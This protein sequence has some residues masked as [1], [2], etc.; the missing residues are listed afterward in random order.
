M[1]E[2]LDNLPLAKS[3]GPGPFVDAKFKTV[4]LELNS[5]KE[6]LQVVKTDRVRFLAERSQAMKEKEEKQNEHDRVKEKYGR[7]REALEVEKGKVQE[8]QNRAIRAENLAAKGAFNP[9]ETRIL[10][11]S[12]NPLSETLQ[13]QNINLKR[14]LKEALQTKGG[15]FKATPTPQVDVNP[16]KL[17]KRLKQSF[18]EQIGLFREGVHLITG[19]R[20]D[21][22]PNM[23]RH[24]FRVRSM[25]AE[26]EEDQLVFQWPDN[27][28]EGEMP[29]T[30][31][32]MKTELALALQESDSYQYM[33]KFNSLPAFL[34]DVQLRQFEKQTV[35]T[36]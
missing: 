28:P 36:G 8:A 23:E 14:K 10:H 35:M 1:I 27:L 24:S 9:D 12:K 22:L 17:H 31:H 29:T 19:F 18:K 7:L 6:E 4:E 3:S 21:M 2:M 33:T 20:I 25:Y 11:L 5:T 16:T 26:R 32:V 15:D 13:Q 30:L 34:A